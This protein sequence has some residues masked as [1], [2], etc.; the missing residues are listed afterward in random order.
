MLLLLLLRRSLRLNHAGLLA[1]LRRRN[2]TLRRLLGLNRGLLSLRLRLNGGRC[3]CRCWCRPRNLLNRRLLLN[4]RRGL[5][6]LN[7]LLL[8]LLDVLRL[9]LGLLRRPGCF[10]RRC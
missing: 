4:R 1:A 2:V 3:R 10:S 8:L 5:L 6:W 9:V 7:L